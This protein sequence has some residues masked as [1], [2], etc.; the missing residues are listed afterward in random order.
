[1]TEL[2]AESAPGP[3]KDFHFCRACGHRMHRS[4][5]ACPACGAPQV[6]AIGAAQRILPAALLCLCLG[7]LGAHRFYVGRPVSAVRFVFT[8][9]GVAV[10]RELDDLDAAKVEVVALL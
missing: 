9:G 7:L 1:M 10:E 2:V 3:D 8:C 6:D 4:A 5:M